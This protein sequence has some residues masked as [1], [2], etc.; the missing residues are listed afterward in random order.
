M[1]LQDYNEVEKFLLPNDLTAIQTSQC[2][3]L[4][5]CGDAAI[6]KPLLSNI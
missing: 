4:F 2:S 3:A 6:N 5:V 1:V